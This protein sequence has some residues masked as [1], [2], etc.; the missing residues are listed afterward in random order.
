MILFNLLGINHKQRCDDISVQ[1]GELAVALLHLTCITF[2]VLG[3]LNFL[4]FDMHFI[5]A[6]DWFAS[7]IAALGSIHAYKTNTTKLAVH[8]AVSLPIT[9]I[10][11]LIHLLE[12]QYFALFWLTVIPPLCFLLLGKWKGLLISLLVFLYMTVFMWLKMSDWQPIYFDIS[13]LIN[14]VIALLCLIVGMICYENVRAAAQ[15]R[16]IE[17]NQQLEHLS[18]TD[19]LTRLNNRY[20]MQTVVEQL[21]SDA[22]CYQRPLSIILMDI[23]NFKTINDA[24]GHQAGDRV[25]TQLAQLLLDTVPTPLV[26]GRWGGDEFMVICPDMSKATA[27]QLTKRISAAAQAKVATGDIFSTVSCGVSE[28]QTGDKVNTLLSRADEAL[29][30]QKRHRKPP[31]GTAT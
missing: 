19:C 9:S 7:A 27:S 26:V 18:S 15:A 8:L 30:Q 25:L 16:L 20:R 1:R 6:I 13:S 5:A 4:I 2:M 12:H 3:L 29:Y 23:D 17:K 24:H 22:Q 28:Y 14:I 11:L 31:S 21:I 10:L